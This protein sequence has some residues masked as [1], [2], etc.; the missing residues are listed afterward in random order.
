MAS[1]CL[2]AIRNHSFYLIR[3]IWD[4]RSRDYQDCAEEY[5]RLCQCGC[6]KT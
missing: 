5:D 6:F 3:Y 4:K 1:F 2:D